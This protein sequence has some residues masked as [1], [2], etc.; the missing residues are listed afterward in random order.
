MMLKRR[1]LPFLRQLLGEFAAVAL[2]DL[3][4]ALVEVGPDQ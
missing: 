4:H 1:A 3:Q 2:L